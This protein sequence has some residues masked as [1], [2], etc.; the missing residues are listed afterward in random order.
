MSMGSAYKANK[1]RSTFIGLTI[2]FLIIAFSVV[3]ALLFL[4]DLNVKNLL[5]LSIPLLLALFFTFV[6]VSSL[7]KVLITYVINDKILI[8][9]KPLM[10]AKE[11]PWNTIGKIEYIDESH[12]RKILSDSIRNQ[13]HLREDQD[14][15]GFIRL[16][17]N[18]TPMFKY[19]TLVNEASVITS[20]DTGH[21]LSLN[22]KKTDG[23]VL[24]KLDSGETYY[25]TPE[26]PEE[27]SIECN[28][29]LKS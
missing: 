28:K 4:P 29:H 26:Y 11:I 25:V 23:M 15:G 14:I 21:L 19:F 16:L 17:R 9:K 7:L 10:K 24:L 8:I 1:D 6:L 2:G 13:F 18:K 3:P 12:T 27:F 5:S 22:V 20:G